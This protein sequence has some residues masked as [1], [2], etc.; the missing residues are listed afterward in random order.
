MISTRQ[1]MLLGLLSNLGG[2]QV[3]AI[4]LPAGVTP[5]AFWSSVRLSTWTGNAF[6]AQRISDNAT[7]DFG[8]RGNAWDIASADAFAPGGWQFAKVYDQSGNANDLTQATAASQPSSNTAA[9]FGSARPVIYD[10]IPGTSAKSMAWPAGLVLARNNYSAFMFCN[11]TV[12]WDSDTWYEFFTG[13]TVYSSLYTDTAQTGLA[14]NNGGSVR[15]SSLYPRAMPGTIGFTS[16]AGAQTFYVNGTSA[17]ASAVASQSMNTGGRFGAGVPGLNY[18]LRGDI[19]CSMFFAS[20]ISGANSVAII[21]ALNS[22]YRAPTSWPNRLVYG[23]SS[24]NAGKY[25]TYNQVPHRLA[26]WS[27][28]EIYNFGTVNGQ[29]LATQFANRAREYG[30]YNASQYCVHTLD[31]PSNDI[32]AATFTSQADA[33]TWADDFFGVTNTARATNTTLPFLAASK[34]AGFN[35][36]V[37]PTCI[38][39]GTFTTVNFKEYARLR[40][41]LNCRNNVVANGGAL[42]DRDGDARLQ[43]FSNLTYFNADQTHLT[44]LGY[45]ILGAID[46]AA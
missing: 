4:T 8:F 23:G 15:T 27:G 39:R 40:Y 34:A 1:K 41:N 19:F 35:K 14:I 20:E 10:G 37:V 36:V 3:Q 9:A 5:A 6:Q 2:A 22:A 25:T 44:A 42:S 46:R 12:S 28:W 24:L 29:T 31:A 11:P 17:T 45:S 32:Q 33:E 16:G 13:S 21:A 18:V 30:L 43:T 26:N 7:Q 38:A